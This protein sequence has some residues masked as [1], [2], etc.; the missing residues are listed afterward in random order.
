MPLPF[1]LGSDITAPVSAE[2]KVELYDWLISR[3]ERCK[4]G[5]PAAGHGERR[6]AGPTDAADDSGS[7]D[8]FGHRLA[9]AIG[10]RDGPQS[11][12]ND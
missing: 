9:E 2:F 3:G 5:E 10:W 6:V 1:D 7:S 12:A 4:V 11:L 8:L